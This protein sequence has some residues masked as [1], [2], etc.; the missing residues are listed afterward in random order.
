MCGSLAL[1]SCH[2]CRERTALSQ[3]SLQACEQSQGCSGRWSAVSVALVSSEVP[4]GQAV[5]LVPPGSPTLLLPAQLSTLLWGA[6]AETSSALFLARTQ[7]CFQAVFRRCRV[8]LCLDVPTYVLGY[9]GPSAHILSAGEPQG[10]VEPE[11]GRSSGRYLW[12]WLLARDQ[13]SHPAGKGFLI[14]GQVEAWRAA[15]L[16]PTLG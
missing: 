2:L 8:G 3:G 15:A 6:Y 5:F 9:V 4:T 1:Q 12:W 13:P 14:G 10:G 16:V 7:S 11:A